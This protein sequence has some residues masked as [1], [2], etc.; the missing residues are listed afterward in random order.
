LHP[1]IN[2]KNWTKQE[3]DLIW[4]L[5]LEIGPK[6][7]YIAKKLN[8]RPEN[9]VKNRFHGKLKKKLKTESK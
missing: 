4:A 3:D 2:N 6:W 7:K 5:Y 8:G 1:S 9:A